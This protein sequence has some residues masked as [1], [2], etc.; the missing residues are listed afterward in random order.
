MAYTL[1]RPLGGTVTVESESRRDVL[2]SRGY[3]LDAPKK[4]TSAKAEKDVEPEP[5]P[6]PTEPAAPADEATTS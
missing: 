2:V 3:V 6:E 5:E 4:K 1:T